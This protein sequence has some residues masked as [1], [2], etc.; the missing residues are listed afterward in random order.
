MPY[1]TAKKYKISGSLTT[2]HER[3]VWLS[4]GKAKTSAASAPVQMV[5]PGGKNYELIRE[6]MNWARVYR[7]DSVEVG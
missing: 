2:N 4:M 1:F 6:L 5:R 3:C 7:C